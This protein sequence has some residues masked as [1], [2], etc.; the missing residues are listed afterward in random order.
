MSNEFADLEAPA[1]QAQVDPGTAK[2]GDLIELKI[3]VSHPA[4]LAVENPAFSKTLGTFEVYASTRLAS[5]TVD[6]KTVDQ[7]KAILQNFTTGQQ[8]LPPL[9]IPYKDPMG[10]IASVKTQPLVVTIEEIAAGPKDQGDIRGIKGV[11]GPTAWSPMWWVLAA[12]LLSALCVLLWR[13]RKK[14]LEGPP[15]PPPIPPD[16]LALNKL[17]NLI[18]S[19]WL[20]TGK[21]KEF[22]SAVS[23]ILRGYLEDGF[24]TPALERTTGELMRVLQ[25]KGEISPTLQ[26]DLKGLLETCDLVK[27]AKFKPDAN[28]ATGAH[29]FAVTFVEQTRPAREPHE[30][31]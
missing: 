7:F 28:E 22:Y 21:I 17:Q 20:T 8:T 9:E 18:Q 29:K 25:R 16:V 11:A 15:P 12:V 24:K 30:S 3:K 14:V 5:E 19:D 1:V 2:L 27:F 26:K 4:A 31:R 6:N 10:R 13:K 23:D